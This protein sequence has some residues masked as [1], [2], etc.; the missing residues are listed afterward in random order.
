LIKFAKKGLDSGPPFW[1]GED[2][3]DW[4]RPKAKYH[5]GG[6]VEPAPGSGG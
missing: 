3:N 6:R 5:V 1:W 2:I 4:C